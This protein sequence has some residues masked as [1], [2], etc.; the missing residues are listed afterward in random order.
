MLG[1]NFNP[2]GN[3]SAQI[4]VC[5][6]AADAFAIR[7]RSPKISSADTAIFHRAIY[8]PTI[9]YCLPAI[10]VEQEESLH[11]IQTKIIP[12]ILQKMHINSNLPT[13]IR[14]GPKAL[15]GL[16]LYDVRTEHGIDQIKYLRNA[17]FSDSP[18]GKLLRISLQ[19]RQLKAGTG[20]SLLEN[21]TVEL[22][23]LTP[24]WLLSVRAFLA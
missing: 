20:Q 24:C 14:H 11:H 12:A 17:I 8:T 7:L 13:K 19:Y 23:Y 9:R 15:G 22:P 3:F 4:E 6:K 18:T 16:E 1:V 5:K 21:P 2:L 10:S